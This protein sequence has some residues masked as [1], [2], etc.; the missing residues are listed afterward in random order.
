LGCAVVTGIGAVTNAAR[1]EKGA[2][3]AVIGAGGVGLN[4]VQGAVLVSRL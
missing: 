2:R 1:G 3:V 4:V